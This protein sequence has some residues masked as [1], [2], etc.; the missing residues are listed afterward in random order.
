MGGGKEDEATG[1]WNFGNV[2]LIFLGFNQIS[3]YFTGKCWHK[4]TKS[5][6]FS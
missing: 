1:F 5:K 3:P 2:L 4:N 6:T